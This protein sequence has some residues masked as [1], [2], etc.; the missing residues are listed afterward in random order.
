MWVEVG[1]EVRMWVQCKVRE[2][3]RA[4]LVGMSICM[5]GFESASLGR[6]AGT[7]RWLGC[8]GEHVL[9]YRGLAVGFR[10]L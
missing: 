3:A 10:I 6:R 2:W 1:R 8:V 5:G 7:G 4:V 9:T